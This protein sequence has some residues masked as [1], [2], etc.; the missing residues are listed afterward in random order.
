MIAGFYDCRLS[1]L[2]RI[3]ILLPSLCESFREASLLEL[4]FEVKP[5]FSFLPDDLWL[6]STAV[7]KLGAIDL[8]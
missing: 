6:L 7:G 2:L 8:F 4:R 3:F 5:G 1:I